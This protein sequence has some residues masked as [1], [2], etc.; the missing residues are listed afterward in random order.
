MKTSQFV[1]RPSIIAAVLVF[2]LSGC[3][4]GSSDSNT[5]ETDNNSENTAENTTET[6]SLTI[7]A[8]DPYIS[9]AEFYVDINGNQ[10]YDAAT[11][12][13]STAGDNPGEYTFANYT[14]DAEVT[15]LAKTNGQHNGVDYPI[16]LQGKVTKDAE[17]AV[18]N[19][20][21]T[22]TSA[23]SITTTELVAIL[24]QFSAKIGATVTEADV[25]SDPVDGLL[26]KP[27][28]DLTD[29][30][31]AKI[32]TQVI[33][34]GLQRIMQG[35]TEIQKLTDTQFI[36]SAT[37]GQTTENIIYHILDGLVTAVISGVK[38]SN[39]DG[40]LNDSGYQTVLSYG[41]PTIK[42]EQFLNVAITIL[43]RITE[44]GYTACNNYNANL[45]GAWNG[46]DN[47]SAIQNAITPLISRIGTWGGDL[48]PRYYAATY[49][50]TI[51]NLTGGAQIISNMSSN[52]NLKAGFDCASKYFEIDN[53]NTIVCVSQ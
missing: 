2:A 37:N 49:Q 34:T 16:A 15:I 46:A 31:I 14:P 44:A 27:I 42:T 8:V 1:L 48:G 26:E 7:T 35:S 40:F 5:S 47:V 29:N 50:N 3:G 4:G 19:P 53:N 25:L 9:S 20:A 41:G 21:T 11:D 6:K 22:A 10:Q 52:A 30:D 33:L 23:L 18:I 39:I 51:A 17:T 13:L 24:N 43:N 36:A 28:A 38:Q 32:R 12:K 45:T